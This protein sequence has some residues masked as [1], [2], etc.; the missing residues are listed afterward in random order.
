[1]HFDIGITIA[2][3]TVRNACTDAGVAHLVHLLLLSW[4]VEFVD[5]DGWGHRPT[6]GIAGNS[7]VVFMFYTWVSAGTRH[8][9]PAR[10]ESDSITGNAWVC[11]PCGT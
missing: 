1:M 6:D 8:M 4:Y 11:M 3:L 2:V 10:S 5:V 9:Q 7:C